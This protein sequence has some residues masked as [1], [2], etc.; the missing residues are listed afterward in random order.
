VRCGET[1]LFCSLLGLRRIQGIPTNYSTRRYRQCTQIGDISLTLNTYLSPCV[2]C[3]KRR[4]FRKGRLLVISQSILLYKSCR[5]FLVVVAI[6]LSLPLDL[7]H[8]FSLNPFHYN[9]KPQTSNF[10]PMNDDDAD[11]WYATTLNFNFTIMAIFAWLVPTIGIEM[12]KYQSALLSSPDWNKGEDHTRKTKLES[13][14]SVVRNAGGLAILA[15]LVVIMDLAVLISLLTH[16]LDNRMYSILQGLSRL[17]GALVIYVISIMSPKWL[18]VYFYK[19]KYK[20]EYLVTVG[21]TTRVLRFHVSWSVLSQFGRCGFFLL[22]FFCG[23]NA[24]TI[25]VSIIAGLVSGFAVDACV[26]WSRR[27]NE[28]QRTT[29]AAITAVGLALVSAVLFSDGVWYIAVVW[30]KEQNKDKL[31]KI[32]S[33]TFGA[34]ALAGIGVHVILYLNA[35]RKF[36]QLLLDSSS[37]GEDESIR[38]GLDTAMSMVS[39]I[40]W[41]LVWS[42]PCR[43]SCRIGYYSLGSCILEKEITYVPTF[44]LA[45]QIIAK[46]DL[47]N[48]KSEENQPDGKDNKDQ[49]EQSQSDDEDLEA[50]AEAESSTKPIRGLRLDAPIE[51]ENF[52]DDDD[53]DAEPTNCNL[54]KMKVSCCGCVRGNDKSLPRKTAN[55]C[56]WWVWLSLVFF[57]LWIVVVLIGATKEKDETQKML[58]SVD[59]QLYH[60]MDQGPVCAFDNKG[61]DDSNITTFPDKDAAHDA[62]FLILH[63]GA[64]GACS[65][66]HNLSREYLTRNFLAQESARCA[67]KSLLGSPDDVTKCLNQ[68]P[69]LLEGTCAACWTTDILCTK[70]NCAFIFL[71]STMINRVG[72]FE[73]GPNTVTS[74]ACEEAIC[75]T[76]QF[77]P[78]S[79]ATRRRMNVTSTIARPGAQRCS[80]VDVLWE[81]IF[82]EDDDDDDE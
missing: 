6:H 67:K 79:G 32:L 40:W 82:P 1:R 74:A 51:I 15:A 59:Q 24:I 16:D 13:G 20:T 69:I 28:N 30:G 5:P 3:Y 25:P 22:P 38:P 18:G 47:S 68:E 58:S 73:V 21:K 61:A 55:C 26:F 50:D 19:A 10:K 8:Q 80:I 33:I 56:V 35:K 42:L 75:E 31:G 17:F 54:L 39:N 60:Y 43:T 11:A 41:Y 66:W 37:R 72:D 4:T 64:C 49:D 81:D 63:C 53:N 14:L 29:I 77:V 45:L 62:G 12:G 9:L 2:L 44:L 7:I 57:S 71:L 46:I 34:W 70:R 52:D 27:R 23:A 76:G 36:A 78:C 48:R 65:D